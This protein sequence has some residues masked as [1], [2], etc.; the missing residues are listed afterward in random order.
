[1]QPP[2]IEELEQ[3]ALACGF[4][5]T[6]A[7]LE[8]YRDL[9][10]AVLH[11]YDRLDAVPDPLPFVKYARDAGAPPDENPLG[12]WA[13]RV[14]VRGADDGP[15][16]GMRFAVKDTLCV[17]GAPM[18][19]GSA[20]LEG[21]RPEIDATVVTRMLDAGA[22]LVGKAVCE[23][24]CFSGGSHTAQSGRVLNPHDPT[25]MAGGSSSGAA[26]L[27]ANG[28]VDAALGTDQGGSVVIPSSWCGI[29][30]IKP[31]F[32][33]VPYTG[34]L[35]SE[36]TVDHCGPLA[37]TVRDAARALEAVAGPD[38]LDTRQAG[39]RVPASYADA[40]DKDAR[41]LR[42]GVLH[43][44]FGL[45]DVSHPE[46][47]RLVRDEALRRFEAAGARVDDA[48]VPMLPLGKDL[49]NAVW[50]EGAMDTLLDA[51][52]MRPRGA[53]LHLASLVEAYAQ[54][55]RRHADKLAPPVKHVALL[56][57][58]VHVL[59]HGRYYAKAQNLRRLLRAEVDQA[60]AAHDVLVLPSVPYPARPFPAEDAPPAE[61]VKAGFHTFNTCPFNLTGHPTM[62]VPAG[63]VDGLPAGM[64]L[65]ARAWDERTLI[66]AAAAFEDG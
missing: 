22:E 54:G 30:G 33:L 19:A 42:V 60:L 6:R 24:L 57:R 12:A 43:E 53:D 47:D 45:E 65:V 56:G 15:L 8:S 17:A 40:A 14:R 21:Y 3:L 29:V 37:R 11:A 27:V 62:S 10:A 31:T 23:D 46:V 63:R 25:R 36:P 59:T 41:D 32:G 26:A 48:H 38:G 49:M 7:E 4:E 66:R 34:I 50:T 28:D 55:W 44:G 58:H 5:A 13:W 39:A 52:G 9:M 16:R 61:V 2:G 64:L 51:V 1:M 35:P 18:R 20:L